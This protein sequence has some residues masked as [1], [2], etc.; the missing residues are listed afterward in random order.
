MEKYFNFK[1]SQNFNKHSM[2]LSVSLFMVFCIIVVLFY[3][4]FIIHQNANDLDENDVIT[5]EIRK[6]DT[7][8]EIVGI[9]DDNKLIKSRWKF[10]FTAKL[11]MKTRSIQAGKFA[12]NGGINYV[13]LVRLL[14]YATFLQKKITIPEGMELIEIAN[15]FEKEL[16]IPVDSF[17]VLKYNVSEF[18]IQYKSVVSIEGFL[19]P[20]TYYFFEDA[21][22]KDVIQKMVDNF[23]KNM[24]VDLIWD[25]KE[26]GMTINEVVTL[27]SIIQGEV[28]YDSEMSK[29]ASV[30]LNRLRK[31]MR[32]Q[33]DPTVQYIIPGPD[34]LLK[35][36]ELRIDSK[37]NTYM[38]KGLP[39]GP[40]N[41]PGLKA[42]IAVI[43]PD[44]TD[45]IYF[46]A[47]GDGYHTF[48]RTL[49]EHNKAKNKLK[50][51]RI[52]QKKQLE[53]L[54]TEQIKKDTIICS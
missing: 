47:R 27:A 17:L 49:L 44:T 6:G 14:E 30:Y 5:I 53:K 28:I 33:A 36:S 10:I 45:Y 52:K 26:K 15:I 32:L 41:N 18:R 38:H 31:N 34:R 16:H 19:F 51:I 50:R 54:K 9:L 35:L 46:V 48:S 4:Y 42:I 3:L 40:I 11:L 21:K 2:I 12:I 37:Y 20:D 23:K 7:F 1:S 24:S 39:P 25:A 29:V 8:R 22:A 43:N 13:S